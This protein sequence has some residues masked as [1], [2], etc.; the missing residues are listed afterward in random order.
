MMDGGSAEA[1]RNSPD[2]S[3]PKE[4]TAERISGQQITA[5][6]DRIRNSDT[7]TRVKVADKDCTILSM[8]AISMF[9]VPEIGELEKYEDVRSLRRLVGDEIDG[10]DIKSI[11]MHDREFVDFV[12]GIKDIMEEERERISNV[13]NP[14]EPVVPM[15]TARELGMKIDDLDQ[16]ILLFTGP[17][18]FRDKEMRVLVLVP[19]E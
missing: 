16:L 15:T 5:A 6:L 9:K 12:R 14:Q 13:E 1:K 7:E 18:T 10:Y 2:F 11:R 8:L 19:K 4:P 17:E 3:E